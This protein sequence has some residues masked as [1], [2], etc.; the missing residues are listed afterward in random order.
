MRQLALMF[1]L[2]ALSFSCTQATIEQDENIYVNINDFD[3][4]EFDKRIN[5]LVPEKIKTSLK[6][7]LRVYFIDYGQCTKC[8]NQRIDNF[9]SDLDTMVNC[10]I[11]TNDSNFIHYDKAQHLNTRWHY[12]DKE[13]WKAK[14]ISSSDVLS[15]TYTN[16]QFLRE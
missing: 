9:F 14:N 13:E 3:K 10:A 8:S 12:I 5:T 1:I 6:D 7:G 16:G 4:S 11:I 2:M 15:Y